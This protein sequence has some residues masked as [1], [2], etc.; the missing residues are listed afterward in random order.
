MYGPRVHVTGEEVDRQ[1]E[2][3]AAVLRQAGVEPRQMTIIEPSLEDVFV[4]CM[5]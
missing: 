1:R 5:R 2:A 3:I 4:A